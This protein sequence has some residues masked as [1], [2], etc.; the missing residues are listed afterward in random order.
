MSGSSTRRCLLMNVSTL[1][2]VPRINVR[3]AA[4]IT[5]LM[6]MTYVLGR[7]GIHTP[8]VVFTFSFLATAV[9]ASMYGPI[10][11]G[12]VGGVYDVFV[13]L[14]SGQMYLPGFTVSAVLSAFIF[15]LFLYKNEKFSPWKAILAQLVITLLV[16]TFLNTLWLSMSTLTAG[17]SF[18]V[19]LMTRL[20]KQLITTPIQM[21]LLVVVLGNPIMQKLIKSRWK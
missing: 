6:A 8:I 17:Y 5:I 10:I 19:L 3:D 13:T 15:G 16:N 1:F 9:L 20:I 21:V 2:R 4:T 12:I 11:A 18:K 7:V 14:L